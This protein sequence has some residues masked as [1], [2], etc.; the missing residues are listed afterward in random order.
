MW[1]SACTSRG[2]RLRRVV[3]RAKGRGRYRG[4]QEK[5][6][7]LRS[8]RRRVRMTLSEERTVFRDSALSSA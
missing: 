6:A 7:G 4:G 3:G 1:A 5:V 2:G 8:S